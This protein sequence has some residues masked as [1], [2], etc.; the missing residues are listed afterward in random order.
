MSAKPWG[1]SHPGWKAPT[2]FFFDSA[3]EARASIVKVYGPNSEHI[4]YGPALTPDQLAEH[5]AQVKAE[6]RQEAL[7]EAAAVI[8]VLAPHNC[9]LRHDGT[10]DPRVAAWVEGIKDSHDAVQQLKDGTP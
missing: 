3:E 6:A 8:L 5:D 7:E 2:C 1:I 4:A 10:E 9:E